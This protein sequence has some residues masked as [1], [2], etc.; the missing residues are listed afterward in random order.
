[1]SYGSSER[2]RSMQSPLAPVIQQPRL[3]QML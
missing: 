3:K 1:M 2:N